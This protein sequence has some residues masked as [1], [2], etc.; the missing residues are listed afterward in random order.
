MGLL[1]IGAVTLTQWDWNR[2]KPWLNQA[3]SEASGRQFAVEGDLSASWHWPQPL[4]EGWHRWVPGVTV[5]GTQLVLQDPP[6]FARPGKSAEPRPTASAEVAR[7]SLKLWPLLAREV[8]IDTLE[9]SGP[10]IS[11]ARLRDG[12]NNWTFPQKDPTDTKTRWT[13]SVHQL[14][15]RKGRLGY[16]DATQDLDLTA[17]VD[18]LPEDTAMAPPHAAASSAASAEVASGSPSY[19]VRFDVTGTLGKARIEG[20]GKA[21]SV[22]TLRDKEVNYPL[23]FTAKAGSVETAVQGILANPGALSGMDFQV[24]LKGASMADLYPL[25]GLVLPNTPAFQTQGRLQGSLQPGRAVWNYRD[26]TGT[27]GQSDLHGNLRFVSGAPRGKLSG[28]ITSNQLR[29]ADLGPVL[30]TATTAKAPAG[31]NGRVLPNAAFATDRWSNMDMDLKFSGKRVIRP[32]SLPLEDLSVHAVL[33]DA[34]LRLEPLHFGVAKGQI[35]SKLVL[36]SRKRPLTVRMDTRVQN[37]RLAALFPEVELTRKSLGRLDGAIALNGQGNSVAQ[38]LGTSNGEA[39]LYVREGTLS[40]ELLDRA[41]L[42]V[43]SIVIGKLFGDD[44]EVQ[45]RCAVADLAVR[46]GIATV[47]TGKLSTN[48]AVVDVTGTIDM[49]DERLNLSVKPASL[50]W[51]FFSLRTP[52][53]VRGTLGKPDVGA[54]PGPLLLRAGAAIA[55]AVAAPAALALIPVTVPG[56]DDDAQCAPL[57]A[58]AAQPVKA[59][60]ASAPAARTPAR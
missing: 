46:E 12:T 44:K 8:V 19:G 26:F 3:A 11:L 17:R 35:E 34:V 31:R 30:G 5:Q 32:D 6:G 51:K 1:L 59:G 2:A 21:G 14:V 7:A 52:L 15:A 47:R 40:R 27:V 39:R 9:L 43:G 45:L 33:D 37:L 10:D 38:W 50:E 48:E 13:F 58:Q 22:L 49:A 42:N 18:T 36:D 55:A 60:R 54:E 24:M 56:A 20:H 23:Q 28:A 4:E 16:S 29:L 57:L 53:Y 25:T 41:A